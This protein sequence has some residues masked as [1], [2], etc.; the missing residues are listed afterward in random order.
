MKA[1]HLAMIFGMAWP[2]MAPAAGLVAYRALY[3]FEPARVD[4]ST[5]P[6]PVDG[7]IAYEVSGS[8]CAGYT[9]ATR[10]GNR[11]VQDQQGE[12]LMDL[13][14][15][16]FETAD[17][18]EFQL[19]QTQYVN[20]TVADQARISVKRPSPGQV[21]HGEIKDGK[22]TQFAVGP[23]VIFPTAHEKKLLAAAAKGET[24]DETLIYD[25]SDGANYFRA[26]TFIGKKREAGSYAPDTANAEAKPLQGLASWPFSIGYYATADKGSDAPVFQASFNMYENGVT[27]ELLFDY[28]TYAMRGR[29]QKLE[30]LPDEACDGTQ[31]KPK[32]PDA[33]GATPQ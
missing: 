28:G 25:G 7:A 32:L 21:A 22:G 31:Q 27:T 1:L 4:S 20:K 13:Q 17:G 30:M 24:R 19:D 12:K 3:S 26:I 29:L 5:G 11:F 2:T 14:S 6:V 16:T 18:L 10:I 9:V 33:Q 15:T 23:E 8:E